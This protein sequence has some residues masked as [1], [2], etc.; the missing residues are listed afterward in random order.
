MGG[1]GHSVGG[2]SV[3]GHS[4]RGH[5]G[6]GHSVGGQQGGGQGRVDAR[7]VPVQHTTTAVAAN[8]HGTAAS[9]AVDPQGTGIGVSPRRAGAVVTDHQADV[10][11]VSVQLGATTAHA[12]VPVWTAVVSV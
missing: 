3:R 1:G 10:A 7:V 4:V 9:V 12:V 5:S 11:V 2:H 8:P 6:R